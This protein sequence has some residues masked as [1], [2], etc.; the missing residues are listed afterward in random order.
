M[1]PLAP[2]YSLMHDRSVDS[3]PELSG[4]GDRSLMHEQLVG[5]R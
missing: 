5:A 2:R 4:F 1:S 3:A